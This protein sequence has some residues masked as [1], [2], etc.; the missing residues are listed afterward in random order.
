MARH[1]DGDNAL[2]NAWVGEM[3]AIITDQALAH[4]RAGTT[5]YCGWVKVKNGDVFEGI[6][7]IRSGLTA[8]RAIGAEMW[9]PQFIAFLAAA[10]QIAGEAAEALTLLEDALKVVERTGERWFAAELNRLKGELLLHWEH[11]EAAEELYRK[12]LSIAKQQEAKLWELRAATS[13]ARLWYDQGKRAEARDLLAPVYD[14]FS[15]G[16]DTPALKEA[17]ALLED[18]V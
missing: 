4:W 18:L 1:L 5:I 9:I 7:V 2:L 11:S 13:L 12:A 16:F 15:A 14:W 6:S 3:V 17:K 8:F 10:Y